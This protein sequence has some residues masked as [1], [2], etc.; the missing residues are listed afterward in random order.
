[1]KTL[2]KT[3]SAAL[4]LAGFGLAFVPAA[5]AQSYAPYA[6]YSHVE[7]VRGIARP[8]S[9]AEFQSYSREW[10]GNSVNRDLDGYG[11]WEGSGPMGGNPNGN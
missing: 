2:T 8:Q 5:Q 6:S 1:M 7:R 10:H 3:T 9:N 4:V 11:S